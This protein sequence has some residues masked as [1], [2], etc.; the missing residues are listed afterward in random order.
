MVTRKRLFLP[1]VL[2]CLVLWV[3]ACN[4][5]NETVE[6]AK[7][8]EQESNTEEKND[9]SAE[10][11][12]N[13]E[14]SDVAFEEVGT[15][16]GPEDQGEMEVWIEGNVSINGR[17]ITIDGKTN[18]LPE[19]RI[20]LSIS[21]IDGILIGG[22]SQA[23]V[24]ENG[25]FIFEES[26]PEDMEGPATLELVFEPEEQDDE[27]TEHYSNG[28][29]G[30]FIRL[31]PDSEEE[32]K[33]LSFKEHFYV[34]DQE[35]TIE[36][37]APTWDIPSDSGDPNIRLDPSVKRKDDYLIVDLESNFIENTDVKA[38]LDI[39]NYQTT[40]YAHIVNVNPDGSATFYIKNP[41]N[42]SRISNLSEY[43]IVISYSSPY[44]TQPVLDAYGENGEKLKGEH[45][46]ERGDSKEIEQ[47]LLIKVDE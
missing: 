34:D 1:F 41:E 40:G 22:G 5:A 32:S 39:P 26:L 25:N 9:T 30:D 31:D 6:E 10:E 17:D 11:G 13:D 21:P 7:D 33:I 3:T 15:A 23:F 43:E 14:E 45:V 47:R 8:T 35:Q 29:A 18:L 19:S 37:K 44:S 20:A 12:E 36:M 42:D 38:S 4:D 28:L 24:E 2:V 46:K 27:I 16:S